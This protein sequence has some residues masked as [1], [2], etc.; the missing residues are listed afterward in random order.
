M[1]L[2]RKTGGAQGAAARGAGSHEIG[3]RRGLYLGRIGGVD[4]H[5]DLSLLIIFV[6][7]TVGLGS[8]AFPRWHPDWSALT[9]W[10]TATVAAVLF[11]AAVLVHEL[12]HAWVGR[13]QGVEV[14]RITLFVFGG[15]AH[16][17]SEPRRWQAEFWMA[18]VGPITSAVIGVGSI[19]LG[20]AAAGNVEWQSGS[21]EETMSALGPVPSLLLW[22]GPVNILLAV[23]NLVPGFPLDGGRVLR[24]TLWGL[25]GDMIRATRWAAN[26]GRLVAAILI[27]CGFAMILGYTLPVFGTGI[28]NGLWIA[29]IG[30][31][32]NNAAVLSYQ[33]LLARASLE[34][35]RV[36]RLM[37][38]SVATVRS[39]MRVDELVEERVMETGQKALPVVDRGHFEGL[40]GVD[41]LR[42][43]PRADWSTTKVAQ[44]MTPAS[45]IEPLH[46]D[47]DALEAMSRLGR[48][49]I[50]A[51]PILDENDERVLGLLTRDD[52]LKWLTLHAPPSDGPARIA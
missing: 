28:V 7:I 49:R 29:L 35:I 52:V 45:R 31:F 30:W 4:V 32:L 46:A 36:E 51:L 21:I 43:T 18:V 20:S 44:I 41:D 27:L 12:S 47:E 3:T 23:F 48:S 38:T 42:K 16:M 6:L 33:Q 40:V 9:V 14:D 24:A 2:E 37:R 15:M 34:G 19:A 39:D 22:L 1:D 13:A 26:A 17:G 10:S 50:D 5:L 8:G 11:L 25:T